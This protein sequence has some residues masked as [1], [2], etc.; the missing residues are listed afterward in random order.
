MKLADLAEHR[1]DTAAE[2]KDLEAASKLDPTQAEPLQGLYDL[3]HKDNDKDRELDSLSKLAMIDQHDR[4]VWNLLMERL[5][6][7]GQWEEAAKV[8][9]GAMFVDVENPKTHRLYARALARTGRFISAVYELNSALVLK[10][11]PKDQAAIYDALAQAYDKLGEADF[12]KQ[13][14]E[15]EK[16]IQG[17][18]SA[19]PPAPG[20]HQH[21]DPGDDGT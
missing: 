13:A 10:P 17:A 14:R 6:E 1:K 9:E 8:G 4:K 12:A 18:P 11:P 5:E 19:A 2:R 3:A 15:Y 7:K 16:Q 21:D 20:R